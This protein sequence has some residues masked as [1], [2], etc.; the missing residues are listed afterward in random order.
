[1]IIARKI[2]N[3]ISIFVYIFIG[4]YALICLPGLFG[5]KPLVVLSGSMTPTYKI[6]SI[7]YYH[8]VPQSELKKGDAIT[9]K[10]GNNEL[11]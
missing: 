10:I 8:K 7:I 9:F 2:L 5:Y 3:I 1:M 4:V 6:G 11:V